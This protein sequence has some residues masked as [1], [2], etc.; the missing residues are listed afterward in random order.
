MKL[1]RSLVGLLIGFTA[2][3]PHARAEGPATGFLPQGQLAANLVVAPG[4]G[5]FLGD[6]AMMPIVRIGAQL[7]PLAV[8]AEVNYSAFGTTEKFDPVPGGMSERSNA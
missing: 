7:K 3:A 6:F 5:A 8:A 2:L 1:R 4:I